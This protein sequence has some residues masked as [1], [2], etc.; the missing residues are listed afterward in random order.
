MKNS[1]RLFLSTV[2][3]VLLN[4]ALAVDKPDILFIVI[5]DL[6]DWVGPLAGH[7]QVQTP[8]IDRL[9]ARGMTFT[10]AYTTAASC[11]PSRTSFMS[12]LRPSTTGIYVNAPD[13]RPLDVFKNVTMMP[14]HFR[15]NGYRTTGGGKMFH[16]HSYA[17]SALAGFND[18]DSWD[19]Y[20][21]SLD[22][23]MPDD[24]YP[25][26]RPKNGNPG[27]TPFM[28]FDWYGLTTEDSAMS[29]GQ[30]AQWAIQDLLT[31]Q[32]KPRLT[33]VGIYRPHLPWYI[34]KK[35]LD[36]YP[37]K[38]VI[39]PEVP[40]DDLLDVPEV[41]LQAEMQSRE[42]HGWVVANDKW[43]AA[44]RGYLASISFADAMVGRVLDALE[45]SGRADNTIVV[46]IS[47]HGWHL[48]H[49]MRWR[50]ME[51]W[52]QTNRVP[53]IVAAPGITTAGSRSNAPVS[54]LDLYPTLIE[55]AG[56]P[57]PQQD[58]E[59]HS[60]VPLLNDPGRRWPHVAISTW[61]R[62]NHA[63][64][65][66]RYRYIRY[67]EG[68]EEL[69]DHETDPNEWHNLAGNEDYAA[70]IH[71]LAKSLPKKN[72]ADQFQSDNID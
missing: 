67:A 58:L 68:E 54:L 20:Y 37:E 46:L 25:V 32:D 2:L 66:E 4:P 21:P 63:I 1:I 62:N 35:Y 12:G 61:K 19:S 55:L 33:A 38:D 56:L 47:D 24:L 14:A 42:L 5:D 23:Q 27:G 13:W 31:S 26:T 51:L 53:M 69:Y 70:L 28:G 17:D 16:A 8:N 59:G 6:N 15:N 11:H 41:A 10:N 60:L 71:E 43:Q 3:L 7:P 40:N 65:N 72:A 44:V 57:N 9:A 64:Q 30:V 49:K 39:L 22:H 50:K 29:D 36:M 48:G 18:P 52:R 45:Q 34:P